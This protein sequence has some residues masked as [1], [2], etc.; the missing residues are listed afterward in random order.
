M[1]AQILL[2][3]AYEQLGMY[4]EAVVEFENAKRA[5]F[6]AAATSGLGHLFAVTDRQSGAEEAELELSAEGQNRHISDYWRAVIC[7]GR[8]QKTEALAFLQ[9]CLRERD[10]ALLWLNADAR[11]A[12]MR[13]D[14][15]FQDMLGQLGRPSVRG[16]QVCA[17]ARS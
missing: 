5:G 3:L 15:G 14:P 7:A 12:A 2:A 17:M 16:S 9:K 1:P 8:R 6:H 11:F 4:E 13:D 10:P